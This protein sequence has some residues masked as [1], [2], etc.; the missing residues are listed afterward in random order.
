MHITI[1]T[2][3]SRGDVQPYIALGLGLQDAGYKVTLATHPPFKSLVC[4][5]GLSFAPVEGDMQAMLNQETG[6][7]ILESGGNP[8]KSVRR[9]AEA[10][11]AMLETMLLDFW[12]ACQGTDVIISAVTATA[13]YNIAQKLG[14]SFYLAALIPITANSD[15]PCKSKQHCLVKKYV[16]KTGLGE[17]S[18]HSSNICLYKKFFLFAAHKASLGL[19][20]L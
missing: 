19:T 8:L 15:F 7:K 13:G 2:V 9:F 6:Q 3:G 18:K 14:I 10:T 12:N 16:Q 20:F 17:Q 5:Y 11:E 4:N 1:L